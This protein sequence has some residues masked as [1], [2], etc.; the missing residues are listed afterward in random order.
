MKK[1]VKYLV[2]VI[3]AFIFCKI[4]WSEERMGPVP[5]GPLPVCLK[6]CQT[7]NGFYP[8]IEG[9]SSKT[10]AQMA[11]DLIK[12][13]NISLY[14]GLILTNNI[15][16]VPGLASGDPEDL[17]VAYI[18]TKTR[19]AWHGDLNPFCEKKWLVYSPRFGFCA[20][21]GAELCKEHGQRLSTAELRI[22]A[23]SATHSD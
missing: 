12:Q 3:I 16:Y 18:K 7:M 19:H 11:A 10:L 20:E 22:P 4:I 14:E 1:W 23:K 17:I 9:S 6:T 13:R 2:A 15:I 21:G 5:L 8:N